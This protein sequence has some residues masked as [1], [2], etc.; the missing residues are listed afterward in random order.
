MEMFHGYDPGKRYR[1][2]DGTTGPVIYTIGHGTLRMARFVRL[3][4]LNMVTI[5]VDVRSVPYS[6]YVPHF[7]K[8]NM[9]FMLPEAGIEYR[10]GGKH[11][12]FYPKGHKP[13]GSLQPDPAS[14]YVR[15]A[16]K[17]GIKRVLELAGIGQVALMCA[18]EN[19]YRCHRHF[20]ITPALLEAGAQVIHIRHDGRREPVS[21]VRPPRAGGLTVKERPRQKTS[22]T[23]MDELFPD[24][25]IPEKS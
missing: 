21:Y 12:G 18:E 23:L 6:K 10:F 5:V 20:L 19:P 8:K 7:N 2:Q 16:F 15:P 1:R 17:A 14:L 22:N 3:L 4:V 24:R 25:D 9:E 11:L 13:E